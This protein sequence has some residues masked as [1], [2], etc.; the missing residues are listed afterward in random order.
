VNQPSGDAAERAANDRQARA[1][2]EGWYLMSVS[3]LEQELARWRSP[4]AHL[5]ASTARRLSRD[6]ALARRDAGNLPDDSGRTL[7]LVLHVGSGAG[8]EALE[9]RR[10]LFEPDYHDPPTWRR[11]GSVPVNVVPLRLAERSGDGAGAWFEQPELAALEQQWRT[12]GAI[13]GLRIPADVRGFVYKT[14]LSLRSAGRPVTVDTV[15]S[16]ISRWTSPG[17]GAR[18]REALEAANPRA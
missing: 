12:T 5:V 11:S 15:A 9:A 10:R 7:R 1:L 2:E 6:E 13:D 8:P 17:D 14:V 18:I 4:G 3:E 16:S